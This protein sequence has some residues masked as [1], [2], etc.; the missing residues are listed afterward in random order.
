MGNFA[1]DTE[2]WQDGPGR[3]SVE[4]SK[5]WEL[6]GPNGGYLAALALRAAGAHTD[7]PQPVSISCQYLGVAE[8]AEARIDVTTLRATK[9]AEA[10]RV[11]LTQR[12][13]PILHALVW[14]AADDLA[15]PSTSWVPRPLDIPEPEDLVV[16]PGETAGGDLFGKKPFWNNIEIRPALR[17]HESLEAGTEPLI[18]GWDRF[19]PQATFPGQPWT[20]AGRAVVLLDC[21]FFPSAAKAFSEMT[22]IA[23]SLDL[24]VG[25]HTPAPDEEWLLAEST[26]LASD[27]GLISA[28]AHLWAPSGHLVAHGTQ[29]MLVRPFSSF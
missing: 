20:D 28:K 25:F 5:D 10:M 26:G 14:A 4:I 22:F 8:F 23:P 29:Q 21:G 13:R 18:R 27:R 2:V 16:L 24:Y 19:R 9:R 7:K 6:I 15:G 11:E 1:T 3:F 12:D 17:A